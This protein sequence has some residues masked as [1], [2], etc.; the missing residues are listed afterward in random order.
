MSYCFVGEFTKEHLVDHKVVQFLY[1][2][3]RLATASLACG[4]DVL[5][6][7]FFT[8]SVYQEDLCM[9]L[10]C[11]MFYVSGVL[12]CMHLFQRLLR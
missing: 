12:L 10:N 1:M 7:V 9:P 8:A 11:T 2:V 6:L 5:V 4:I 3:F